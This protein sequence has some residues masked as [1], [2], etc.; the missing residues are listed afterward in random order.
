MQKWKTG[1]AAEEEIIVYAISRRAL[2]AAHAADISAGILKS[3]P[4]MVAGL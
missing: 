3:D 1:V 2:H 4:G